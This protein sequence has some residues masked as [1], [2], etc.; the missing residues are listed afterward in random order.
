MPLACLIDLFCR[1]AI[2]RHDGDQSPDL[3][4]QDQPRLKEEVEHADME[5]Q[6]WN[7]T[8]H[9]G[10]VL[11]LFQGRLIHTQAN[12]SHQPQPTSTVATVP[13]CKSVCTR[14]GCIQ[15]IAPLDPVV[16]L[17]YCRVALPEGLFLGETLHATLTQELTR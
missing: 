13:F 16:L 5:V 3:H 11:A 6:A 17:C 4:I 2:L 8:A 12:P 14:V 15:S 10:V 7:T 9:S 1:V